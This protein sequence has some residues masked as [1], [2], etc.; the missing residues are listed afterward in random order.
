MSNAVR[1]DA[2]GSR[3]RNGSLVNV[4]YPALLSALVVTAL[5][6]TAARCFVAQQE[7]A[8]GIRQA[9]REWLETLDE[10]QRAV[11]VLPY[12]SPR[13]VDWHFIPKAERKGLQIRD[14]TIVQRRAA[15]HLLRACLSQVGYDKATKIMELEK[16]LHELEKSRQGGPLRDPER[17]YFT[18]FG[19]PDATSRWGL[20]VEG[21][22]LSL[23]F[24]LEGDK[25]ISSTP[26]VFAANPAI[27]K[28]AVA[29]VPAGLRVLDKEETLAFDL[30]QSLDERQRA[31]AIIAQEPL[32][33]VRAAGEPQPPQTPPQGLAAS[34]MTDNQRA[35]LRALV[36]TY[37]DTMP[38]EVA[39]ARMEAIARSGWE[40]V[41]F[42][43]AG[44]DRPGMGHY[45][46]IQGPTFLIEFVNTQPDAAGNPANHIHSLWRDMRGDFAI[47]IRGS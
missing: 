46:R 28:S 42:A 47:A 13:R 39:A 3:A 36:E 14:M 15:L 1:R 29:G 24:V 23:N 4:W 25:V 34:E 2:S 21:H 26:A 44:A 30:L 7:V 8:H 19:Q 9:A 35:L 18:L 41:Y 16:V 17:Y 20:S 45:Y 43:W 10:K 31:K 38:S 22:H 40:N 27:M 32:R 5:V 11:A 33:E 6:A 37:A 12:D